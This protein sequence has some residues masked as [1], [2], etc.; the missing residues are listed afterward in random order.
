MKIKSVERR[1]G[2]L[3]YKAAPQETGKDEG[4]GVPTD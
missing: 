3:P 1:W 4:T 2:C